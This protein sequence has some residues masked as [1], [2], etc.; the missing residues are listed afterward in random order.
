MVA[1]TVVLLPMQ[2]SA[3]ILIASL[4][5]VLAF[6]PAS[7]SCTATSPGRVTA[8]HSQRSVN[9]SDGGYYYEQQPRGQSFISSTSK[10]DLVERRRVVGRPRSPQ[11]EDL[12]QHQH[13]NVSHQYQVNRFQAPPR[14]QQQSFPPPHEAQ[15][16]YNANQQSQQQPPHQSQQY[17]NA[18][19]QPV[20]SNLQQPPPQSQPYY[21]QPT[22]SIQQQPI[23]Y[24]PSPLAE[25][26]QPTPYTP[27]AQPIQ[28][29]L[30]PQPCPQ[31]SDNEEAFKTFNDNVSANLRAMTSLLSEVK[32]SQTT[33]TDDIRALTKKCEEMER[34][35]Y[36]TE[37]NYGELNQDFEDIMN[38][39]VGR[40]SRVVEEEP[41]FGP[42]RAGRDDDSLRDAI[43]NIKEEGRY[44]KANY[45]QKIAELKEKI[46]TLDLALRVADVKF[47]S[48]V[49]NVN[50]KLDV[51]SSKAIT[52]EKQNKSS[53]NNDQQQQRRYESPQPP[54]PMPQMPPPRP[55]PPVYDFFEEDIDVPF[56]EEFVYNDA[57]P[58]PL[59]RPP[60]PQP[61]QPSVVVAREIPNNDQYSRRSVKE[62]RR[63]PQ[64]KSFITAISERELTD[65]RQ[66]Y[67]PIRQMQGQ[68]YD[69]YDDGYYDDGPYGYGGG[70]GY[71]DDEFY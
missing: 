2:T 59:I 11:Y 47:D 17:N 26:Q 20:Q 12:G 28:Q 1:P 68:Y 71:F 10:R 60:P 64:R 6:S 23:Q 27:Q 14:Y 42:M 35:L 70:G 58:T 32:D 51:M 45:N 3:L 38:S 57:R 29:E 39:S 30:Q 8:L 62:S 9:N 18:Y 55:I 53:E 43:D 66:L 61:Q 7:R 13:T 22:Q 15:Q 40:R 50:K 31:Q 19:Q 46:S 69:N 48:H 5:G 24:Q 54:P 52:E 34:R 16:Y 25:Y 41:K 65:R 56:E 44:T 49:E 4:S 63:E 21:Q 36:R 67:Q 33:Q 37:I